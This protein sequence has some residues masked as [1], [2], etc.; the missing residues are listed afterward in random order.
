MFESV[1]RR[2]L[3][4]VFGGGADISAAN[5]LPVTSGA[6]QD[7]GVATGGSLITL[8]D[9][10]KGWQ[11][12]IWAHSIVAIEIG[13]VEY[14]REIDSN[15]A[16]TLDFTTHPLPVPVVAGCPYTIRG[17]EPAGYEEASDTGTT[18]NAWANALD[19]D[20]R[21]MSDKTILLT[22]TDAINSLN[23]RVYTRAYY[24]G[25]D[26]LE[27]AAA[28]LAPGAQAR[29]VLNNEYARAIVQVIDTAAPNH[30]AYQ[31]DRIGRKF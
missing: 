23:Y 8:E 6:A 16:D 5:P 2:V 17:V 28:T 11:V 26:F 31:I 29:V 1:A 20:T 22:N 14:H 24:T 3:R 13:G 10:T 15:T 19:W 25:Q 27:V 18:T 9:N 30:A 12:D 4:L 21:E 7:Q